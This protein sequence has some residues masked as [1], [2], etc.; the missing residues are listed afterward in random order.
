M[1]DLP[2]IQL[3]KIKKSVSTAEICR[4][5]YIGA[6]RVL[7]E[8]YLPIYSGET[9]EGYKVRSNST[10]F[11][12]MYAPI[13]DGLVGLTTKKEPTTDGFDALEIEDVDLKGTT[14]LGFSKKLL[15]DSLIDGISFATAEKSEEKN[16]IFTKIYLLKDL[17]S[18]VYEDNKLK[19]I[20]FRDTIE[21]QDGRFGILKQ[22]RYVVFKIGGGEVWYKN[23][24]E[25][26]VSL[27]DEWFNSLSEIPIV[28]MNT[29]KEISNYELIPRL[30]D[31][32]VLNKVHLNLES[33]ISNVLG[34]VGNP[35]PVFYGET[36]E[37][38]VTI[39]VKD[40]LVFG[41]RS[42]EGFEYAE[43][44]GAGVTKLQDKIE[45][46]EEQI[47]KLT[48]N[49]LTKSDSKTVIDAQ[50]NQSKNSS[51]LTDI[52]I[53]IES[54]M[55]TLFRFVA[56]L[57]N[58][59]LAENARIEFKKDFDTTMV[60]LEIAERLLTAGE[61]SR[62]TFYSIL[63]TGELPKDFDS[64]SE[65]SKIESDTLGGLGFNKGEE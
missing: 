23:E 4:D 39:G 37:G 47:N 60:N 52:V 43:I 57:E 1:S 41:D 30:Y 58:K 32:A 29:G 62:Q 14:L 15:R 40:A 50:E 38:R 22:E 55:N 26:N 19:Q 2:N 8:K 44:T 56:E 28:A 53:E 24:G 20:V 12:N 51:F 18:Y 61:M 46:I 63:Q 31:T 65:K 25:D 10:A 21:K 59:K 7:T 13:V 45:L 5:F 34:V 33:H 35:I 17:M 9:T 36:T 11:A 42:K 3:D 16:R 48:F 6:T 54:C 27:K 49:L 64:S